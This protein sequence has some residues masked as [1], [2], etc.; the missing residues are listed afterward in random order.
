MRYN[1]S[2]MIVIGITGPLA[3]GKTESAHILQKA[4]YLRL[5]LSD[6]VR[7]EADRQKRPHDRNELQNIG[8]E[9]RLK[10]GNSVL[11][12]RVT[13]TIED[14]ASRGA[15]LFVIEGI[16]N[17]DEIGFL[18]KKFQMKTI[19]INANPDIRFERILK[20][21]SESDI[22]LTDEEIRHAMERDLGIG[23]ESH[24]NNILGC[25]EIIDTLIINEGTRNDLESKLD[26]ALVSLG[27]EGSKRLKERD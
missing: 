8:D 17:P 13:D 12:Q 6:E 22:H 21:Q 23:E 3:S 14:N 27:V 20:R 25:L 7:R 18:R 2:R 5:S 10:F 19:G 15:A 9:L 16:K 11:A 4:G 1:R 26:Q 24:G